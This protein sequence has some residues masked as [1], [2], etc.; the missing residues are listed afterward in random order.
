MFIR[1]TRITSMGIR[2]IMYYFEMEKLQ[3]ILSLLSFVPSFYT[4]YRRVIFT[5]RAIH[6]LLLTTADVTP[7]VPSVLFL[8]LFFSPSFFCRSLFREMQVFPP[9]RVLRRGGRSSLRAGRMDRQPQGRSLR[10]FQI[11]VLYDE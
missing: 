11:V 3:R 6:S 7:L 4:C 2:L 9:C 10:V 1:S 8:S 5:H